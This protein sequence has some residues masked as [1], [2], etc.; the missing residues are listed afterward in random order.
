MKVLVVGN[1]FPNP[2][3]VFIHN[4]I[5]GLASEG[6]KVYNLS[7]LRGSSSL[8]K[9]INKRM[10]VPISV[11]SYGSNFD[12]IINFFFN[13]FFVYKS[14]IRLFVNCLRNYPAKL[15]I[16]IFRN[17]LALLIIANRVDVIHFEWNNQASGFVDAI[18]LLNR[19]YLVSI[20]G[21]GIASQPQSDDRLRNNLALVFKHATLIHSI[22]EELV[23]FLQGYPYRESRIRIINPAIDLAKIKRK[24]CKSWP[25]IRIITVAH[26]RWKKN[27]TNAILVITRLINEGFNIRYELIGEGPDRE[28]MQFVISELKMN[29]RITLHGRKDHEWVLDRLAVSDIF[30]MPSIQEGFCNSVIEAQ[31]AGL[32]CV[33]TNAEGLNEN[34]EHGVTGLV[35]DKFDSESMLLALKELILHEDTQIKFGVAGRK[36][37][38][39]KFDIRSQVNQFIEIYKEATS[40]YEEFK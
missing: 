38:F 11:Y 8:L 22:S 10:S 35:V 5:I 36:R 27:L 14:A 20:R 6:I 29:D 18:P 21:R 13:I 31:A 34:V 3:Q 19:P 23:R 33:V 40:L 32:P 12:F 25:E 16:S 7:A 1:S 17:N 9:D 39:A 24:V 4:K 30:L 26:Y 28:Q 37:A 15:A 2:S